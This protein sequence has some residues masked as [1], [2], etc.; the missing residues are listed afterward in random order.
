MADAAEKAAARASSRCSASPT[1]ACR[2]PPSPATSSPR[3]R[4]ATSTRCAPSYLQDWLVDPTVPLAWRLQK[5]LAGSGALGDIGAHI[6]DLTQYITGQSLT[7][8]SGTI[9][10][11]HQ[12]APHAARPRRARRQGR[13]RARRRSP[14]TTSRCS[15][16]ASTRA[17]SASSRRPGSPPAARTPCASRSPARRA[18]SRS[19]SRTS[20]RSSSTTRTAPDDRAGL[21][22]DPRDRAASTPT[23]RAWWPAGHMLGYEHGFSHQAKDFVEAIAAGH[24]ADARRSPTACRCSACSPPSSRAPA[25]GSAW[26]AV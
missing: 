17:C 25:H 8:V 15:P 20:T 7:S 4:S 1:A 23:S 13:Q 21:H 16:D 26:T 6:I 2:P 11:D 14:S 9:E 22:E 24:P 12:A 3:A 10:T 19:T 5:E 18:R